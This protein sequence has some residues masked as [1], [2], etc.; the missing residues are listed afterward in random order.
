MEI[1]PAGATH[2][3]KP[4][5]GIYRRQR[6]FYRHLKKTVQKRATRQSLKIGLTK[7]APPIRSTCNQ[8]IHNDPDFRVSISRSAK[9]R[10]M[11]SDVIE[12]VPTIAPD[13]TI[14]FEP[15]LSST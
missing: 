10:L 6:P 7:P 3:T 8:H 15:L 5:T 13:R 12:L 1:K 14:V 11:Y 4:L 9:N 2:H